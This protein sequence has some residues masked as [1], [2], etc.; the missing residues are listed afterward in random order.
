MTELFKAIVSIK[1]S[2]DFITL[3]NIIQ[4]DAVDSLYEVSGQ[5]DAIAIISI[6]I[7]QLNETIDKI[8]HI[9]GV[10]STSTVLVLKEIE[11]GS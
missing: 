5:Y 8:K 7:N 6:P 1:I 11:Y 10:A 3:Q 4:L 2:N 9:K